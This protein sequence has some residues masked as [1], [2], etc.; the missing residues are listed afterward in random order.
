MTNHYNKTIYTLADVAEYINSESFDAIELNKVLEE[1]DWIPGSTDSNFGS[2]G[3]DKLV[4]QE[5]GKVEV[6]KITPDNIDRSDIQAYIRKEINQG[7]SVC[8]DDEGNGASGITA[9]DATNGAFFIS[10]LNKFS[11]PVEVSISEVSDSFRNF[12]KEWMGESEDNHIYKMSKGDYS[13]LIAL[14]IY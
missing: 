8:M 9:I 4:M 5:N 14:Y 10:D 13:V 6:V 12:I 2:D 1:N 3:Y 11:E 7:N